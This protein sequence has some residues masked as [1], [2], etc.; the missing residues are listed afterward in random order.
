MAFAL[1]LL[2]H[3]C[4]SG[5]SATSSSPNPATTGYVHFPLTEGSGVILGSEGVPSRFP[6]LTVNGT[7]TQLW[8]T[9]GKLTLHASG[10]YTTR[11]YGNV[12]IDSM[13]RL[14]DLTGEMKCK[15]FATRIVRRVGTTPVSANERIF[16][17]GDQGSSAGQQ[18]GWVAR[19][20][21][22]ATAPFISKSISFAVHTP[23]LA[24]SP[25]PGG[26]TD[27]DFPDPI[28]TTTVIADA[29]WEAGISVLFAVDNSVTPYAVRIYVDGALVASDA[30]SRL[31]WPLPGISSN[32]PGTGESS[33][34]F[35]LFAQ[36]TNLGSAPLKDA[37]VSDVWIGRARD[38]AHLSTI[39]QALHANI[40]SSPY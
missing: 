39:A 6:D 37:T 29:A 38:T 34:G 24:G 16:Q 26:Q 31:T 30:Q 19:I 27:P 13:M 20:N 28:A 8:T 11:V 15:Y 12:V 40:N 21:A 9:P 18:G 14:D 5:G 10:N 4:G 32:G 2:L 33:N 3:G 35:V 7:T 36:S 1:L 17:Y 22:G 23:D 25:K